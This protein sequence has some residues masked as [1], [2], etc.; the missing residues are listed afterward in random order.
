GG[1]G[2]GP[3]GGGV[4]PAERPRRRPAAHRALDVL[5]TAH[6]SLGEQEAHGE[7]D[8]PPRRAHRH[9]E[10]APHAIAHRSVHQPD[11]ERLLDGEQIATARGLVVADALDGDLDRALLAGP[12]SGDPVGPAWPAHRLS[13]RRRFRPNVTASAI[14]AAIHRRKSRPRKI[15]TSPKS[16]GAASL[17]VSRMNAAGTARVTSAS[18]AGSMVPR[19][20]A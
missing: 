15:R 1:G 13:V 19:A 16:P 11:L 18:T 20:C 7:L 17:V 14:I 12:G 8:V 5:A 2:C 9:R 3:R 10:A 6:H 4:A